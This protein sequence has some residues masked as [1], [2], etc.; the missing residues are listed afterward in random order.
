MATLVSNR[1]AR[2]HYEL[3]DKLSAGIVLEGFE[4]KSLRAGNVSL[5][6]AYVVYRDT[7]AFLVGAYIAPFQANNTPDSYDPYRKRKLLLK[8]SEIAHIAKQK[9]SAGLTI[10]PLS[11]YTTP[12]GLIK[13]DLAIARGKKLHDKRQTLRAREDE[14]AFSRT[15]KNK[16]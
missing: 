10:I 4:V 3:I 11:I 8:K 15:L 7:E 5:K 9:K 14:R 2:F 16:R 6:G 1:Q 13:V 12:R